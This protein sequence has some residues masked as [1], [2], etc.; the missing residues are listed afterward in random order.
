MTPVLSLLSRVSEMNRF[1]WPVGNTI[2]N[3]DGVNLKYSH[4]EKHNTQEPLESLFWKC[5]KGY[6]SSVWGTFIESITCQCGLKK[7]LFWLSSWPLCFYEDILREL[8]GRPT[9]KPPTN[10]PTKI[11]E[12]I[13]NGKFK[14]L[15]GE[16][17]LRSALVALLACKPSSEENGIL[18]PMESRI[19]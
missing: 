17:N 9:F 7:E 16:W 12:E 10:L 18:N 4:K 14:V 1:I 13:W 6:K 19:P 8:V 2:E 11:A 3:N 15:V 5:L